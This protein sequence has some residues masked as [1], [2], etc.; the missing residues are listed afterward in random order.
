MRNY[1]KKVHLCLLCIVALFFSSSV[2]IYANDVT[3]DNI[4]ST[5]QLSEKYILIT[6]ENED[7]I[8]SENY[9]FK[10]NMS[11]EEV[12]EL[13][14]DYLETKISLNNVIDE[15]FS[16]DS[17]DE[18]LKYAIKTGVIDDTV[19]EKTALT[20]AFYRTQFKAAVAAGNTLGYTTAANLL[21]HS[22]QDNPSSFT[23]GSNTSYAV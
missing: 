3:L 5:T 16:E 21:D 17:L 20:K 7:M 6:N 13:Y 19:E 1:K 10:I 8:G 18:F 12:I 15:K 11:Y 2:Q 14:N 4:K 23:C 9:D 22:L